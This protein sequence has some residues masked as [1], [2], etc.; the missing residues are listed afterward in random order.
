ML[1]ALS[2]AETRKVCSALFA[3]VRFTDPAVVVTQFA[4]SSWYL[5]DA[6][7]LDASVQEKLPD[8]GALHAPAGQAVEDTAGVAGGVV[9]TVKTTQP[10]DHGPKSVP[11]KARTRY[12]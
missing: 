11:S 9:S 10:D 12:S 6:T 4:V 3:T 5:Y 7:S 1:P 2:V 8:V